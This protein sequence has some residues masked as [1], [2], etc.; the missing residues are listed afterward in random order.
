MAMKFNCA[1]AASVVALGIGVGPA[2]ASTVTE[3]ISFSVSGGYSCCVY[4]NSSATGSFNITY[5]PTVIYI[6]QSI[7]GFISD[8]TYTVTDPSLGGNITS[9]L[10][11]ITSFDLAYGVLTLYSDYTR[12]HD[13]TFTDVADLVIGINGIPTLPPPSRR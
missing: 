7:S 11:P 8:L 12:D 2:M 10:N 13:K 4:D 1:L 6:D 5:D 3:N 9:T